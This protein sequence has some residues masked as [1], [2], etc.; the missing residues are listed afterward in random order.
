MSVANSPVVDIAAP[1]RNSVSPDS[2][3]NTGAKV[4]NTL[5]AHSRDVLNASARRSCGRRS[6]ESTVDP[7][8]EGGATDLVGPSDPTGSVARRRSANTTNAAE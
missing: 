8:S 7:V 5:E 6:R 4:R 1:T 3:R 2:T